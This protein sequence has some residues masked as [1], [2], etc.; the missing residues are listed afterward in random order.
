VDKPNTI[1]AIDPGKDLGWAVIREGKLSK[2]G[3]VKS[4]L[5]HLEA[6]FVRA[7]PEYAFDVAV[8]EI[9]QV[10]QQTFWKGDPNDLIS[11]ALTAG[12]VVAALSRRGT[13]IELVKPH[14]WKGTRP[15]DVDNK[16]TEGLLSTEEA[17]ALGKKRNHNILDAIGI[18]L[19]RAGR[20]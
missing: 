12:V 20:R 9:P 16:F 15:K 7:V 17:A 11:V 10:Y 2:A 5:E 4:D 1:I 14:A 13:K 6:K 3:L 19:W 18:G 8:I